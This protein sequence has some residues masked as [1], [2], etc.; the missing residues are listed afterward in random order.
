MQIHYKMNPK[1]RLLKTIN[2]EMEGG[3]K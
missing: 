2:Q 3:K 1:T